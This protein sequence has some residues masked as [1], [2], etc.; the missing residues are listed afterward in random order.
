MEKPEEKTTGAS[1][2]PEETKATSDSREPGA[3]DF[4]GGFEEEQARAS[5][6]RF[7]FKSVFEALWEA[8]RQVEDAFMASVPPEVTQHLVNAQKE[9]LQAGARINEMAME[10]LDKRARRAEEIHRQ[11]QAAKEAAKAQKAATTGQE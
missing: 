8:E 6:P 7:S 1:S 11:Q 9:L 2:G 10:E 4:G 5:G 3:D